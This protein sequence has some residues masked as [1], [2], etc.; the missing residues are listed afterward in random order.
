MSNNIFLEICNKFTLLDNNT[1]IM[2]II[3]F[4]TVLFI[5]FNFI[6][7]TTK[8]LNSLLLTG[9]IFIM[10]ISKKYSSIDNDLKKID[11]INTS[12]DLMNFKNVSSD[13][14]ICSIYLEIIDFRD[15]D[16]YSFANSLK[17]TDKYIEIY[18]DIKKGN[19]EYAQLLD[20]ASDKKDS[21]LNYLLSISNS[22]TP[23]IGI[24]NDNNN[25][26]QNPIE[27]KLNDKIHKL[28]VILD[29][30]WFE[31]ANMARTIYETQ[32]INIM[33]RPIVFDVNAPKPKIQYD[34]FN[35][36]YGNIDP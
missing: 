7:V 3:L 18:N 33:S 10:I 14:D 29:R 20:I 13:L 6:P 21:A 16:K 17:D 15:I 27:N 11:K 32:P 12:L 4:V 22:I 31:M 36:F 24:T 8:L 28:R 1:Q 5:I 34:G 19:N 35:I 26:I 30:Y 25:I 2:Y 9:V 23:N